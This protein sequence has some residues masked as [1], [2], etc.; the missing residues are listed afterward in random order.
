M[1]GTS[2]TGDISIDDFSFGP[3]C[4]VRGTV[5]MSV[6][7]INTREVRL[8]SLLPKLHESSFSPA[9]DTRKIYQSGYSIHHLSCESII[10]CGL[11]KFHVFELW[12]VNAVYR[13]ARF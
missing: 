3:G 12:P 7:N 9:K 10:Y 11:M 13:L 2:Y 6:I 4:G 8:P 1:R 5:N